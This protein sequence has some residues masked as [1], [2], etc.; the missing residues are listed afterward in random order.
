MS[1]GNLY[2]LLLK[3]QY[4]SWDQKCL[5]QKIRYNFKCLNFIAEIYVTDKFGYH[6]FHHI[7]VEGSQ[8]KQQTLSNHL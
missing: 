7:T 2:D 3:Y 8:L 4:F 5:Q 6:L 1:R